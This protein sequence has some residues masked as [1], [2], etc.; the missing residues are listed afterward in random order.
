MVFTIKSNDICT[1]THLQS[2]CFGASLPL[3]AEPA[4][5][6]EFNRGTHGRIPSTSHRIVPL[7]SQDSCRSLHKR[8]L[9]QDKVGA[10]NCLINLL[11]V[12]LAMVTQFS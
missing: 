2:S 3:L 7:K 11:Q 6:E 4:A 1:Q 5:P 8:E 12:N 9:Q 10:N